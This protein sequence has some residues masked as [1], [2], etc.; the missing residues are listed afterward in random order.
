MSKRHTV[1]AKLNYISKVVGNEF[2]PKQPFVLIV[3]N[4]TGSTRTANAPPDGKLL[5][6]ALEKTVADIKE[7]I[8]LNEPAQEPHPV[9][10][11]PEQKQQVPM[12]VVQE[13]LDA[14]GEVIDFS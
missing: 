11:E 4:S 10:P 9:V 12:K 2:S 7:K 1:P 3:F 6:E 14:K 8:S 13:E 5:L